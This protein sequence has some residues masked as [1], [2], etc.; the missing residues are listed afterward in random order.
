MARIR[1]DALDQP[2]EAGWFITKGV[3]A[4]DYVVVTAAQQ[5]LSIELKG[6]G[7]E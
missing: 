7:A 6:Q 1:I 5:L 3:T 4:D 2:T